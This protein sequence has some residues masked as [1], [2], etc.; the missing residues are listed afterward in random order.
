MPRRGRSTRT[1]FTT[2]SR[3]PSRG[4]RRTLS[5]STAASDRAPSRSHGC[6]RQVASPLMRYRRRPSPLHAARAGAGCA[7]C[8]ALGLAA[9]LFSNPVVLGAVVVAIMGAA[10]GAGVG[11]DGGR[12]ARLSLPLVA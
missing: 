5:R 1:H 9:L 10:L 2:P 4:A 7:Y 6:D 3:S 8:L 11:R 12:A